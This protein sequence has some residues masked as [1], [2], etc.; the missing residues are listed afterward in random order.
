MDPKKNMKLFHS[1]NKFNQ[2]LV[3]I[4]SYYC[5]YTVA[6]DHTVNR[7][8][9]K[10]RFMNISL[11]IKDSFGCYPLIYAGLFNNKWLIEKF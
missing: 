3:H 9:E 10:M 4:F 1:K 2:N 8:W 11:G 6:E 5:K 7:I